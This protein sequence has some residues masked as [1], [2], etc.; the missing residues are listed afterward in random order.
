MGLAQG[1]VNL[2]NGVQD[3]AVGVANLPIHATNALADGVDY[4]FGTYDEN[5][6]IRI[7]TIPSP[8]WS[9]DLIVHEG[10][11]P[12]GWDDMHGWSKFA[13]G[14]GVM[15][16]LTAGMSKAASAVDDAGNCANWIAKFVNGGCFVA[17]TPVLL[18]GMPLFPSIDNEL[19][20]NASEWFLQHNDDVELEPSRLQTEKRLL[21]P[22]QDVPLGARVPTKNPRPWE[23]ATTPEPDSNTWAKISL[24]IE[25]NDGGFVDVEIIRPRIWI[26]ANGIAAGRLLP[27]NLPELQVSG[28]AVV[29]ALGPC[30]LIARGEGSVIT[31][32]F[33]TREIHIVASVEIA[34]HDGRRETITGTTIHPVWSADRQDWVPLGELVEGEVLEGLDGFAVVQRITI[35]R[36]PQKVYNIEV[37]DEHVFQVGILSVLVHNTVGCFGS[38]RE[39]RNMISGSGLHAHHLLEKRFAQILGMR[40]DDMLSIVINPRSHQIFTNAWRRL[41]PYE[42]KPSVA[43]IEAAARQIYANYPGILDA[44]GL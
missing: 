26:E 38:Y 20:S 8:D 2:V 43:Q 28:H 16:L 24:W 4:T 1:S 42:T 33:A 25:R 34:G 36:S 29:T 44:L 35:T 6:R 32:R 5:N 27:L 14:E 23:V 21:I 9:R 41:I 11:T 31:A 40:A 15:T 7:P 12:G 10:G 13:G 30:P 22:I 17:G 39:L 18:S 37:H 3:A 19:W